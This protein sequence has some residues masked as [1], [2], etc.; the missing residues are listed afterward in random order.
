MAGQGPAEEWTGKQEGGHRP[1][2]THPAGGSRPVCS[3]CGRS[4][5]AEIWFIASWGTKG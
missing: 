2:S 3:C 1:P 5:G 4:F